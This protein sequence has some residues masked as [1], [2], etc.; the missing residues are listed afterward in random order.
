M[1][2]NRVVIFLTLFTY[3]LFKIILLNRH[4]IQQI[5]NHF[6]RFWISNLCENTFHSRLALNGIASVL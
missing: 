2:N 5:L 6:G 3:Y 1:H 4:I